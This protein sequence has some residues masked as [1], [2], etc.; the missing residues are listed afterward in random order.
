MKVVHT[1]LQTIFSEKA[2]SFYPDEKWLTIVSNG[3]SQKT[4]DEYTLPRDLDRLKSDLLIYDVW[5]IHSL[6]IELKPIIKLFNQRGKAVVVQ[7]WGPDYLEASS[8]YP[9]SIYEKKT[10]QWWI[11]HTKHHGLRIIWRELIVWPRRK[12]KV[13]QC[14]KLAKSV[15]FCLPTETIQH[16]SIRTSKLR[17]VYNP[18]ASASETNPGDINYNNILLGNSGN[19]SNNHLDA[20]CVLSESKIAIN[21]IVIPMSYSG[22]ADYVEEVKNYGVK[23]FGQHAIKILDHWLPYEEYKEIMQAC[24]TVMLYHIRQQAVGNF[25]MAINMKKN[26]ILNA[27]GRLSEW[28]IQLGADLTEVQTTKPAYGEKQRNLVL[29]Y[30]SRETSEAFLQEVKSDRGLI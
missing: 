9:L 13:T 26:V 7:T 17:F 12:R 6:V 19:I 10:Q 11:N 15:H 1:I 20:L 3:K 5:V 14:L 29:D 16:E 8:G 30:L 27:N 23:L 25:R 22:K 21:Q 24:G 28:M 2:R 4:Q 18:E